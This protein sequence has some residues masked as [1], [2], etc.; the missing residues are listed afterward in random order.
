MEPII[1]R[2]RKHT[3]CIK[4]DVLQEKY[5][6]DDLMALWVAD[7]DFQVPACVQQS[8]REYVESGVYGYYKVPDCY[9]EAF[10]AWEKQYHGYEVQREWIRF[11]PGVVPAINWLVQVM[12]Q[13]GDGIGVMTPVY[14]P[15]M[16]AVNDN[17][18]KLINC[19]L[20]KV[21]AEEAA[22]AAQAA[23]ADGSSHYVGLAAGTY[24]MDLECFEELAAT[25]EMKLFILCSPHN[26]VGRVWTKEELVGLLTIC[27]KYDIFVLADEIHQDIIVGDREQ[28]PAATVAPNTDRLV[29]MTAATKTF[30]LAGVQNSFVIIPSEEVRKRWDAFVEPLHINSGNAFGYVAVASAYAGGRQWL[31]GVLEI[32]R[33]NFVYL[34]DTLKE[35]LPQVQVYPLEGTYLCWVDLAAYVKPENMEEVVQRQARL[36]VDYGD[37]FGG[38]AYGADYA[39]HIRINLA[40]SRENIV[41]AV[42]QLVSAIAK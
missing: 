16:N 20:K 17:G 31:D 33:G 23:G 25:G 4:W 37:W 8:L 26:P 9:Y 12:T 41:R 5:G 11:A 29:T 40:T 22:G 3:D 1:Y 7:M 38:E 21:T 36:A 13:P 24:T 10:I 35:K 28:I 14:Y 39:T 32:I 42:E 27:D 19:P 2:E 6:Q 30:N 34:K 18:R 15:F